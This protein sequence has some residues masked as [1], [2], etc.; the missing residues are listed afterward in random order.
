[1]TNFQRISGEENVQNFFGNYFLTL[2]IGRPR[3]SGF[4]HLWHNCRL[5]VEV[6]GLYERPPWVYGW[7]WERSHSGR[8]E[9]LKIMG[10]AWWGLSL[11]A[12]SLCKDCGSNRQL[13]LS[14]VAYF[15]LYF[16]FIFIFALLAPA[17]ISWCCNFGQSF[18]VSMLIQRYQT[19]ERLAMFA[20]WWKMWTSTQSIVRNKSTG[21]IIVAWIQH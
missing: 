13:P 1:M 20:K 21:L 2:I 10:R 18:F 17:R 12:K 7:G 6:V 11:N 3:G 19:L 9:M 5:Y 15:F 4:V 14:G 8:T 16:W